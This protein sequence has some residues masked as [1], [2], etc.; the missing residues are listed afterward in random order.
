MITYQ[1]E[2]FGD[3]YKEAEPIF[4]KYYKDLV[5][6]HELPFDPHYGQY[7]AAQDQGNLVC[8]T[9]RDDG[10]LVGL[11]AFFL[12][13]YLYSRQH[14]IAIEDLY[15]LAEPYRKGMTGI[16]LLKE[17]E[18]VLKFHGTTIVNVVCKAHQDKT[19]LYERLGYR[20]TEKHFSKL[21]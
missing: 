4:L 17:A 19:A 5:P 12:L 8:V 9:C 3:F 2:E 15:Y 6:E 16:R 20:Y 7:L 21:V 1:E 10:R 18:K 14:R 13:P 11:T